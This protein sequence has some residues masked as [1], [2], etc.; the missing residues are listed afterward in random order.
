MGD[1]I[2]QN[3]TKKQVVVFSAAVILT[4]LFVSKATTI[5]FLY[6]MQGTE[7][8]LGSSGNYSE[9]FA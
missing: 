2:E 9:D 7:E 6:Y 4:G 1:R 8:W 3:S 5:Y